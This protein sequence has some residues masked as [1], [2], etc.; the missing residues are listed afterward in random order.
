[1]ASMAPVS[2][3]EIRARL[4]MKVEGEGISDSPKICPRRDR[5]MR[6]TSDSEEEK[7]EED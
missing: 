4:R 5:A 2:G 1:M 7:E 6:S 3:R